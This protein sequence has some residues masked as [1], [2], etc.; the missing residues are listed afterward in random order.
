MLRDILI[1]LTHTGNRAH[2]HT[3]R[4]IY[5]LVCATGQPRNL[6]TVTCINRCKSKQAVLY[7][8]NKALFILSLLHVAV[9]Q[10]IFLYGMQL[11]THTRTQASY[12]ILPRYYPY[13]H[14]SSPRHIALCCFFCLF[15]LVFPHLNMFVPTIPYIHGVI[16]FH[17]VWKSTNRPLRLGETPGLR[18][19]KSTLMY[20]HWE[21][22]CT[23]LKI[24]S[25]FLI[26]TDIMPRQVELVLSGGLDN[27]S[28]FD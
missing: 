1:L 3:N 5:C 23:I 15:V 9:S 7:K 10:V 13:A 20:C 4:G 17:T 16:H 25:T 8:N 2:T 12:L 21:I 24:N 14:Y 18:W 6:H 28:K 26:I 27:S 11:S 22:R 19:C